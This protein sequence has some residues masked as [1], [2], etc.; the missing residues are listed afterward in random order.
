MESGVP[1]GQASPAAY[2]LPKPA[3][4][5]RLMSNTIDLTIIAAYLAF[6]VGLGLWV[7]VRP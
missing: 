5:L 3:G 6:I 2:A 4:R 7:A 1:K